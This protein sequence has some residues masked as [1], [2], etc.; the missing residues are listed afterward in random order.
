MA[1][2]KHIL[3]LKE[4][5]DYKNVIRQLISEFV[6]TFLYLAVVLSAGIAHGENNPTVVIALANGLIVATIVQIIGHVS[7]G[8]INPAVTVGALVCGH[9]KLLKAVCY[10]VMQGLGSIA[11]AAVAHAV[12]SST[13]KGKLGATIP[14]EH[15]K[16]IQVFALEFLM[17]FLLVAV[18]LSVVDMKRGARGLGS[19]SLAIG[20]CVTGCLCSCLPYTGSI[21]PARTLGPAIIMGIYD[22]HWVY[23]MGP[24]SGG[25]VAGVFYRFVLRVYH[26]EYDL[27]TR[28][29]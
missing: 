4:M 17:T 8:H 21:N 11:G 28:S 13:I 27:E 25:A 29:N 5:G 26:E 19:A 3:G 22:T 14:Y 10:I 24:I 1:P 23:W 9:I 18:V 2:I 6:G 7:G 12:S 15:T 20:L 16:P